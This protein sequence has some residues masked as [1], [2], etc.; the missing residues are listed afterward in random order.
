MIGPQHQTDSSSS[1]TLSPSFSSTRQLLPNSSAGR[2]NQLSSRKSPSSFATLDNVSLILFP[3]PFQTQAPPPPPLLPNPPHFP[4][5][6]NHSH[7]PQSASLTQ[8]HLHI[9]ASRTSFDMG[10]DGQRA[11]HKMRHHHWSR[12]K[13]ILR[14]CRPKRYVLFWSQLVS[15][16][17]LQAPRI[18]LT[19]STHIQNGTKATTPA[20]SARN[21][22]PVLAA[23][24]TGPAV[25]SL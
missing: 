11:Q 20:K 10:L 23:F 9:S 22:G 16:P 1:P 5:P 17:S 3:N 4:N 12:A 19:H 6:A 15:T 21:P 8:L 2:S 24:P 7:N 14:G 25:R 18:R 13:S